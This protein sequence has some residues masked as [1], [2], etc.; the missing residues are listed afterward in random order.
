MCDES[1]TQKSIGK[2]VVDDELYGKV[3]SF[4]KKNRPRS[5]NQMMIPILLRLVHLLMKMGVAIVKIPFTVNSKIHT[6]NH[7]GHP[8]FVFT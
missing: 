6:P 8:T 4:V 3:V 5:K 1:S 2:V 7:G